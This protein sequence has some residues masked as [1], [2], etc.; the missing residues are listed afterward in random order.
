L[1]FA[2]LSV[3]HFVALVHFPLYIVIVGGSLGFGLNMAKP[4]K[5]LKDHFF[6]NSQNVDINDLE[7]E[8]SQTFRL[9]ES[10]VGLPPLSQTEIAQ[11]IW[12]NQW[13]AQFN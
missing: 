5:L 9:D 10:H 4:H 7:S 1:Y 13:Y 11:S 8:A 6:A 2:L 12:K 3:V